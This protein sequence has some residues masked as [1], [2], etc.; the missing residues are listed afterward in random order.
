M[1]ASGRPQTFL[2][3]F[4]LKLYN[5]RC[6]RAAVCTAAVGAITSAQTLHALPHSS[7]LAFQPATSHETRSH[8]A[9][10]PNM[11][12]TVLLPPLLASQ[13]NQHRTTPLREGR[14]RRV[15]GL[16]ASPRLSPAA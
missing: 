14:R 13:G 4:A 15:S 11:L 3:A 8:K 1:G 6:R 2:N 10:W 9:R 5:V 16:A 12:R 7:A